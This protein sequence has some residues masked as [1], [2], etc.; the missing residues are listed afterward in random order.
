MA[1]GPQKRQ[2][3]LA[4]IRDFIDWKEYSPAVR[5]ILRSCQTNSP[6]VV[7]YHFKVLES[8]DHIN[9][10]PG[11]LRSITLTDRPGLSVQFPLLGFVAAGHPIPLPQFDVWHAGPLEQEIPAET[12]S[13]GMS[14]LC[15]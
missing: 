14:T 11:I 8:D 3:I 1:G 13:Q 4:F 12:V 5:D 6:A 9:R 15:R 10:K 2:Q 7:Q